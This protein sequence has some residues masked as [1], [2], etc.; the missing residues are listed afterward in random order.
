LT[1]A[2]QLRLAFH[3]ARSEADKVVGSN[4]GIKDQELVIAKLT[5]QVNAKKFSALGYLAD[6]ESILRNPHGLEFEGQGR[7]NGY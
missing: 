5:E 6:E 1:Q 7:H 2:V 3:E 4:L